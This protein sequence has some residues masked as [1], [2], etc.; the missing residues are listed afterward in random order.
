[1]HPV[2]FFDL[3]F[4]LA[5]IFVLVVLLKGWRKNFNVGARLLLVGLVFFSMIY[6]LCLELEWSG[7]TKALETLE[8]FIGALLPMWW[9][10]VFYALLQDVMGRK[11]QKSQERLSLALE[12]ANDGLWDWN[13]KAGTVYFSPRYYTMLGYEANEFPAS[14]E[15]WAEIL[16][17]DDRE[18]TQEKIHEHIE[19]G[20]EGFEEEF[21]LRTKDGDWRWILSRGKVVERDANGE[22]VRMVGT[23]VD[24]TERKHAEEEIESIFNL[25]GYMICVADMDGYF[26]RINSSFEQTLGYT[27]EELLGRPFFDFMHPEDKERTAAVIKERLSR[28]VQVIGFE[29]RYRCKDGSYKWLSWTSQPVVEK[30]ILYAIAY[31]I[32]NRKRAE[33]ALRR[34]NKELI[35]KNRELESILYAASHDLR[36]PL[37]NI[38]GFG[39]E[40]S[41][42]CDVIRSWLAG[43]EVKKG[44]NKA[45]DIALSKD[46]PEALDFILASTARMDS[47]LSGLL[48]IS[49]LNAAAIQMRH[50]DMNDLVKN[51]VLSMEYQIQES[52]AKVNIESLPNCA[53]DV[54]QIARVFAN[55]LGN[56]LK[57][58][59]ESRQG[60]IH[61]YGKEEEGQSIYCVEDNGI[62]I[63]ERHHKKIFQIFYQLEP[64]KEKGE[65]LGL[66]IVSHIVERHNGRIWVESE[67][68]KGSRFFV[69]LPSC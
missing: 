62:G 28:G 35:A 29:N 5:C 69:S 24:I 49:R 1:M 68:G 47:L 61:I 38:Q 4:V 57:F 63:A 50:I 6:S 8:D 18:S 46:I 37:V 25:T 3:I 11:L 15:A 33:E 2:A 20:S 41:R 30:G 53:G 40:L 66:S 65:G 51:T 17:P 9:A 21:R 34:L 52:S 13:I 22:S 12:A 60:R 26:R 54:S 67:V 45:V 14:Y 32:T 42:S 59:D 7:I 39:Y 23:H 43:G 58:P 44:P 19:R 36:S 27:A 48:D 64:G 55:L 10:F 16:H 56:A 31:D